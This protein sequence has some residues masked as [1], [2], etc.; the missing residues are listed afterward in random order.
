MA[1]PMK[2]RLNP[3]RRWAF[4]GIVMVFVLLIVEAMSQV[5]V[6]ILDEQTSRFN[7]SKAVDRLTYH[8]TRMRNY[9]E[10]YE[11]R[12]LQ[13]DAEIGWV[14]ASNFR[15]EE[16]SSNEIGVRGTRSYAPVPGP[17]VLRIAAFGD[18]L[19]Y[20]TE[21][22]DQ[23]VWSSQLEAMDSNVEVLNYAV[24]GY[25]IDQGLLLFERRGTEL[26]PHVFILGIADI[27]YTRILS[28][29][30]GFS[31]ENDWPLAKPRFV[32]TDSGGL[33]ILKIPY[34]GLDGV[35]LMA[36]DSS[37]I[38]ELG[39]MDHFYYPAIWDSPVFDTFALVRIGT[40]LAK[41]GWARVRPDGIFVDGF[42]NSEH[43]AFQL[44][45]ALIRRFEKN[46]QEAGGAF[47]LLVYPTRNSDIWGPGQ[48]VYTPLIEG[49]PN[50]QIVDVADEISA[51]PRLNPSSP[52]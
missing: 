44:V 31:N 20:G 36:D 16:F 39:D 26:S 52:W 11:S 43:E 13:L 42:M 23:S 40:V 51:D 29:Y 8:Q 21:V 25:G 49:L 15:H 30:R 37:K 27:N 38:L 32:L 41:E 7:F 2:I 28:R 34:P 12:R 46:V 4:S 50:I 3:G 48:P 18:S 6:S 24:G 35:K 33:D 14:Y 17:G 5:V 10:S 1:L 9:L 47:V 19:V 45:V 22:D